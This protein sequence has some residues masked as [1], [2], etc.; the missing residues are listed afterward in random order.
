MTS[1]V[2]QN[3]EQIVI[4]SIELISLLA[5]GREE[6]KTTEPTLK[7]ICLIARTGIKTYTIAEKFIRQSAQECVGECGVGGVLE[8]K[9]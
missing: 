3:E 9:Q 8:R 5:R 4:S 2:N 1:P 7:V 6:A